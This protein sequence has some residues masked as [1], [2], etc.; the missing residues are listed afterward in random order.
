MYIVNTIPLITA[1][2][3]IT[4]DIVGQ[5]YFVLYSGNKTTEVYAIIN[6]IHLLYYMKLPLFTQFENYTFFAP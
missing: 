4:Y 6:E 2:P 5:L 3:I 1:E